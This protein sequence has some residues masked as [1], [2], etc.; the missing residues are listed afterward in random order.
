MSSRNISFNGLWCNISQ[1]CNLEVIISE[2]DCC[3]VIISSSLCS[4]VTKVLFDIILEKRSVSTNSNPSLNKNLVK[5]TTEFTFIFRPVNVWTLK[6]I[7]PLSSSLI[8]SLSSMARI[9]FLA[10]Q[11]CYHL[12]VGMGPV[13]DCAFFDAPKLNGH[14]CN[15]R[16]RSSFGKTWLFHLPLLI[17]SSA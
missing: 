12:C 13:V 8:S 4:L 6:N 10:N 9:H 3:W 1:R 17:N 2:L 16:S 5:A 7:R 14:S 11:T 15:Q